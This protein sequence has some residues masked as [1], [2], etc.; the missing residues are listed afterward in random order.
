MKVGG[1]SNVEKITSINSRA[2]HSA[3]HLPGM[4]AA[5]LAEI[6]PVPRFGIVKVDAGT[7]VEAVARP[8]QSFINNSLAIRSIKRLPNIYILPHT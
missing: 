6:P 4:P 1:R 7:F 5:A 8:G 2:F 3:D